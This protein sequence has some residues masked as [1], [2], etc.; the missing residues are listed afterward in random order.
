M[1]RRKKKLEELKNEL[2]TNEAQTAFYRGEVIKLS[3]RMEE[4]K[5]AYFQKRKAE[6]ARIQSAKRQT[7]T[8]LI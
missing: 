2:A 4:L 1:T 6:D 5:Q 3:K 7:K 8:K